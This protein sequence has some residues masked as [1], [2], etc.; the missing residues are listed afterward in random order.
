MSN[1]NDDISKI[2]NS[3]LNCGFTDQIKIQ[4]W[5]EA[6]SANFKIGEANLDLCVTDFILFILLSSVFSIG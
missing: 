2:W 3:E 4:K 5:K 6:N 1:V